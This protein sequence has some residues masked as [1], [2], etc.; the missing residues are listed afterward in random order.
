MLFAWGNERWF[1]RRYLHAAVG[2][3]ASRLSRPAIRDLGLISHR[4]VTRPPS[5]P[6]SLTDCSPEL[7]ATTELEEPAFSSS[8]MRFSDVGKGVCNAPAL[9]LS[10]VVCVCSAPLDLVTVGFLT[11]QS[12]DQAWRTW[13]CF[14]RA[15]EAA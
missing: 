15:R 11:E 13:S 12:G 7:P 2:G 14:C 9:A 10:S 8:L 5:P 1:P 6:H 3:T 4:T